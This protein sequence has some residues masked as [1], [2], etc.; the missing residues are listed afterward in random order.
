VIRK[1]HGINEWGRGAALGVLAVIL[2]PQV[3][4]A[5]VGR[6]REMTAE[7]ELKLA[8]NRY[9][10]D[11]RVEKPNTARIYK[12]YDFILK[13]N[14]VDEVAEA[15]GS[16]AQAERLRLYLIEAIVNSE[17]A[18]F[19]D[20]L[21]DFEQTGSA[22][23]EG[24]ELAYPELLK[25]L[26]VTGDDDER[27]KITA[28]MPPLIETSAVFRREIRKRRNELY[29]AWGYAHYADFYAQRENLDVEAVGK[30]AE[31]FIGESQ[32]LYDSLY[33]IVAP[34]YLGLEPR[35]VRFT[36]L[37]FLAQGTAFEEAFPKAEGLRRMRGLFRGLGIDVG[38]NPTLDREPRV[39]KTLQSAAYP[40]LV[41]GEVSVSVNPMEAGVRDENG[42]VYATGEALIYT[43][44][45][46]TEFELAYL[47]NQSAQAAMAWIPRFVLD[48]PGWIGTNVKTSD[49]SE[50]DYLTF[51]AFLFL[52][53]ARM[54]ASRT[55]LELLAYG[56]GENLDK[57]FRTMMKT[58]T[59]ARLSTN[60]ATRAMEFVTQLKATSRFHGLMVASGV[61]EY[62]RETLG[63]EWYADGKASS[64]LT[65]LW[66][67]G[68]GLTVEA[69]EKAC[70]HALSNDAFLERVQAMLVHE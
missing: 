28:L 44:S 54:L 70:P 67:Q 58:A 46:Q 63:D 9:E 36:S 24:K 4:L 47:V 60:D 68:G 41:P 55:L 16:D 35:K 20:E 37:P 11:V 32:A 57:E 26:A 13:K 3:A 10:A 30:L 15:V 12:D 50:A 69:I 52:Y 34:R 42:A 56:G 59:G 25:Q 1:T 53:E 19:V 2:V 29:Q 38:D 7:L 61:R 21:R 22:V 62:L 64:L 33:A 18:S 39:G 5:D 43:L 27:R 66:K 49:F 8:K 45:E 14:K 51:R 17:L 23:F 40:V 65:G 6:I 31:A 48:E